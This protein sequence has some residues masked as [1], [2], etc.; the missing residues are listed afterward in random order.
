MWPRRSRRPV[1]RAGLALGALASVALLSGCG[2]EVAVTPLCTNPDPGALP[3]QF[4]R[5]VSLLTLPYGLKYGDVTLGCGQKV[6]P[7]DQVTTEYTGWLT[8]GSQFDSSRSPGRQPF[9]FALGE[10]QVIRGFDVG[11]MGMRVGGQRRIV[12]PPVL[13]YGPEGVPPVVPANATLIIDVQ[14]LGAN[15]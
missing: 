7:G 1:L 2:T 10:Q 13:G 4:D 3:D 11:V 6:R 8:D 9:V 15:H 5:S 12:V 14:V